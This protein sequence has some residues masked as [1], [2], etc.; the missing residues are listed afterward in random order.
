M[1]SVT[2]EDGSVTPQ[3]ELGTRVDVRA[4]ILMR[5][6]DKKLIG[7]TLLVAAFLHGLNGTVDSS[8]MLSV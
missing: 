3:M 2:K 1:L 8:S 6:K 7:V 4:R 5:K